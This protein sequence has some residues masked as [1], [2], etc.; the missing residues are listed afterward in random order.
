[1]TVSKDS[2]SPPRQRSPQRLR[3][4]TLIAIAAATTLPLAGCASAGRDGS[5]L[6]GRTLEN[7]GIRKQDDEPAAARPKTVPLRL[8]AGGNL[9]SGNDRKALAL[10][11]KVYRLRDS[12]RFEQAPFSA[13]LDDDAERNALGDDLISATEIVLQP[14]QRHEINER[15][16]PEAGIVGVVALFRAPAPGRWRLSFDA[17]EAEKEGVTV[18]LHACALTT[19]SSALRS[20]INGEPHS[21][22]TAR[23][24]GS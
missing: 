7:I 6:I 19:S 16:P 8:W 22:A 23:C 13:F 1:M 12:Q 21:L 24:S 2:F 5:G 14:S 10:V 17:L 20:K 4:I 3:A 15:L 11:V 18:G 9:N